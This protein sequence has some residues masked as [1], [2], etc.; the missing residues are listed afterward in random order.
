M[1]A[2]RIRAYAEH[3]RAALLKRFEGIPKQACFLGAS[4]R[5]VFWVKKQHDQSAAVFSQR[6]GFAGGSRQCKIGRCFSDHRR[7]RHVSHLPYE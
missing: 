7:L 1:A 4:R 6:N 2:D 5:H 3:R